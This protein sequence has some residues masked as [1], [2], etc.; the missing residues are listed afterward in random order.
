MKSMCTSLAA[1]FLIF[2]AAAQR[3]EVPTGNW[4]VSEHISPL[5]EVRTYS[6]AL[7]STNELANTIGVPEKASLV[8]R[9][10]ENGL[11]VYINWVEVVSYDMSNFVGA[12]KTLAVWR[13]DGGDLDAKYWDI[14]S[15]GTAAGE[16]K[17]KN[18][19]KLLSSIAHADRFVVRLTG[20]TK[21]DA[22]FDTAGIDLVATKAART[23][24]LKLKR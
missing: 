11:A 14:S 20:R 10:G 24:G 19:L 7:V 6:A 8:I 21:Q 12:P 15:T 1:A 4:V 13:I 16:F 2:P 23:C 22:V 3:A 17:R 9:C 18:A 5:T